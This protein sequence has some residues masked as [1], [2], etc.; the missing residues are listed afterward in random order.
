MADVED[1]FDART[2]SDLVALDSVTNFDNDT[3][4]FVAGAL[5][6]RLDILGMPQSLSMKW[7]SLRQR[8]V[9]FSLI[10]TSSGPADEV[11]SPSRTRAPGV[12]WRKGGLTNFG[13]GHF[14][15]LDVE[16]R[17]LILLPRM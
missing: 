16:V 7:I 9:A 6:S 14:F 11:V 12:E 3:S 13:Y 17:P 10:R 8:P 2:L 5:Y 15:H 1:G 4:T